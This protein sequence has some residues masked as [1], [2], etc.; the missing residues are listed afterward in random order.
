MSDAQGSSP[1]PLSEWWWQHVAVEVDHRDVITRVHEDAHWS[2]HF[3]FMTLTSAGIAIL[4][5]LLSSPAVVIG[6]MLISP[7]MDPIIG[8]GFGLALFDFTQI[9][10]CL[11]TLGIGTL[12]A[13]LLCAVIVLFSP[14]QAVTA[15]IAA[16]T[17]P[18]LLDLGVAIFSGL[19][20]TYAMIRGRHGAIVGVAIAVAL[21]PPI[22]VIGFGLATWN[23]PVLWGSIFLFLTNL[24]AIGLS[25][26]VLARI[27][28]FGLRL[29][30]RQTGL[31]ALLIVGTL[32]AFAVP[33]GLALRQIAQEAIATREASAAIAEPF[34]EG[35]RVTQLT[36]DF[37]VDPVRVTAVVFTPALRGDAEAVTMRRLASALGRPVEVDIE[38]VRVGQANVEAAQLAEARGAAADR[39][40]ARI[41]DQLALVAGATR[42]DVLIDRDRRI[43]RVRAATLPGATLRAYQ[44]LEARASAVEREWTILLIPPP[45]PFP[46]M[47]ALTDPPGV[48]AEAALATVT[49]AWQRL[50]APIGVSGDGAE[51]IAQR[52]R[53]AGVDVRVTEPGSGPLRFAWLAPGG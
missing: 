26:A 8:F 19:A 41:A 52:L 25:A 47:P 4:G 10:R 53:D 43:A 17:R 21:M 9:R 11:A 7:L 30:P 23:L 48:E 3:A 6:A 13:V 24:M 33:L 42:E 16:R 28:G 38:Q 14:L 35:A 29:S 40:A 46:D 49:W 12:L 1:G 39:S 18:N 50:R 36:V 31:Q 34:G 27:Y 5:L 44:E 45:A 15:E 20:G 51:A 37:D 32:I 2:G 22:A